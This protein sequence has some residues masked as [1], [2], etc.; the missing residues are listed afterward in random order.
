MRFCLTNGLQ[1]VFG[2]FVE[3]SAD[4]R[5][6]YWSEAVEL[7]LQEFELDAPSS[8]LRGKVHLVAE[9]VAHWVCSPT[10]S[11]ILYEKI[12]TK[13]LTLLVVE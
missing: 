10:L 7:P 1:W 5:V 9:L 11:D 3:D 4:K 13:M 2:L 6:A 12:I 8:S